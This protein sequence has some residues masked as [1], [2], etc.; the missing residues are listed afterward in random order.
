MER[1]ERL[2]GELLLEL[3]VISQEQLDEALSEQ[4]KTGDFLGEILLKKNYI[5][6]S[7]SPRK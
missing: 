6:K 2:L 3:N 1:K 4:S 5:D 7:N